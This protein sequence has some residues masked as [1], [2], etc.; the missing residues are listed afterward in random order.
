MEKEKL[1][2]FSII[3]RG[4]Q[5]K[6]KTRGYEQTKYVFNPGSKENAYETKETAF[7]GFRFTNTLAKN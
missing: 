6:D 1:A 2:V 5:R 3:G 7:L 4:R